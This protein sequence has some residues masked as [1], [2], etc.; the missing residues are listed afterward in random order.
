MIYESLYSSP[1]GL[2]TVGFAV[3]AY[4]LI[5]HTI[6]LAKPDAVKAGLKALPRH[7]MTGRILIGLVAV[8]CY[9]LFQGLNLGIME[10]PQMSMGEFYNIRGILT[11]AVVIGAVLVAIYADEF[12]S[13]RALG[14]LML[15][16]ACVIL[17]AAFLKEPTSRLLV[18]I[19]AYAMI[20]KGLFF[21]GM[22]YL[23]RDGVNW[24]T[25]SNK[26]WRPAMMAGL[27]YGVVV[28]IATL[29]TY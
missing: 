28:L 22:P 13:V 9:G 11:W 2:K 19:F 25:A 7:Q 14:C 5:A 26:R 17:D 12:L 1:T 6:G 16:A 29:T 15:L 10:I 24:V 3:T 21:V 27:A 23:F 18:V 20:F 8:W 4:L